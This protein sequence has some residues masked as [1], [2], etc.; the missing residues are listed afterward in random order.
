MIIE[1]N[2]KARKQTK[3]NAESEYGWI[4]ALKKPELS[5]RCVKFGMKKSHGIKMMRSK[6]KEIHEYQERIK[7][8]MVIKF[9][10]L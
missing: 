9:Y 4:D 1:R 7:Q 10:S 8:Y 3:T 6:L 2:K 5:E